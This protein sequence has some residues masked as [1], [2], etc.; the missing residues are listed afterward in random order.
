MKFDKV[1][2]QVAER[3]GLAV[4]VVGLYLKSY[5]EAQRRSVGTFQPVRIYGVLSFNL[6]NYIMKYKQAGEDLPMPEGIMP[7]MNKD[8]TAHNHHRKSGTYL[9]VGDLIGVVLK[10]I[11]EDKIL[12]M[13]LCK[14]V[15]YKFGKYERLNAVFEKG[16]SVELNKEDYKKHGTIKAWFNRAQGKIDPAMTTRGFMKKL[17]QVWIE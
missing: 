8:R 6:H 4:D 11:G 16:E 9:K 13:P 12:F 1:I 14:L 17:K 7:E 3:T 15:P 5:T 10:Q 2:Q